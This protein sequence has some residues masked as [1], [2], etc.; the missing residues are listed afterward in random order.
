MAQSDVREIDEEG[1]D[2][3]RRRFDT[4]DFDYIA[5]YVIEEYE[6]R[7]RHRATLEKCWKE[8]DRQ[9]AMEPEIA[10]KKMP[11]GT[12]DHKKLWMSEVE[13]P[14]QA[15]A[16]EVLTSDARR[17]MFPTAGPWFRAHAMTTDEYLR[18]TEFQPLIAGDEME[19]PS[20]INQDNADKLVEGFL[21][22]I[23]EQKMGDNT[24]DF[25]TRYDK[26]NAEAFKYGMGVGRAGIWSYTTYRKG[27]GGVSRTMRKVPVLM[28]CS[29]K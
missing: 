24:E 18:R 1:K 13:L 22:Q 29:I 23:F 20:L 6:R 27:S 25:Y 12:L 10:F 21:N 8:I 3:P 28:P 4:R 19:V 7:R 9:L 11:N 26:I 2:R 14:L 16:L 5:E 17:L 15:Q